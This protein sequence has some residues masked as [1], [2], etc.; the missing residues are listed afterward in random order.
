MK[1]FPEDRKYN[2]NHSW[3]KLKDGIAEVGVTKE[4]VD[5]IKE[6]A[7]IELPK[8]GLIKQGDTYLSMESV[9]WSGHLISPVT[10]E[11]VEVNEALF[12]EPELLNKEPYE[13]WV[14]RVKLTSKPELLN[15]NDALASLTCKRGGYNG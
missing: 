13:H 5:S 14:M 2:A 12:D 11:I 15:A 9:K 3:V 10:G 6:L 7:F 1:E 8:L 4:F